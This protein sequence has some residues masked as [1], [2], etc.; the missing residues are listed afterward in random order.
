[1]RNGPASRSSAG[2]FSPAQIAA[3]DGIQFVVSADTRINFGLRL[4]Q[5]GRGNP[6]PA[7]FHGYD[8]SDVEQFCLKHRRIQPRGQNAGLMQKKIRIR[9]V[10]GLVGLDGAPAQPAYGLQSAHA[11]PRLCR[12]LVQT[13]VKNVDAADLF[14]E[15]DCQNQDFFSF[16]KIIIGPAAARRV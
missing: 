15:F 11:S 3:D 14:I 7:V 8:P 10:A 6:S 4:R 13:P 16:P 12:L 5:K 1:V 9:P 2:H